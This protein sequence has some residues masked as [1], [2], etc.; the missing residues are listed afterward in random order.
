[1]KTPIILTILITLIALGATWIDQLGTPRLNPIIH[2]DSATPIPY[3][4]TPNVQF[5]D[6][7]GKIINL[8]DL[9]GRIVM[10]NFWATWCPPCIAEFPDL[11]IL[12]HRLKSK[13]LTLIALSSDADD[14]SIQRFI[15]RQDRTTRQK[16][17]QA[18][19]III[20][21]D[22]ERRITRDVFLTTRYPETIIIDQQGNMVEKI[23]GIFP[24]KEKGEE[25]LAP[26][27]SNNT[28]SDQNR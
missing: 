13:N 20:A 11:V 2:L 24:W 8:S 12:A 7:E 5:T 1:M 22:P 6:L 16:L 25:R 9:R 3:K 19:N 10:I 15:D 27:L 4:P 23:A 26:L 14:V 17:A 28:I 18:G 21:R